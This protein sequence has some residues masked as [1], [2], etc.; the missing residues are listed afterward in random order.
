MKLVRLAVLGASLAVLVALVGV[1]LPEGASGSESD[2]QPA[3]SITV[4]GTGSVQTVP[5][6]AGLS[7][8]VT[9]QARSA[10]EALAAN[11]AAMQ[12]VIAAVRSAGVPA[13]DIQTSSVSLAPRTSDDGNTIVGYTATN[14]VSATIR[15]I[16]RAGAVI[17]LAVKAGANEVSGPMLTRS[18][19]SSLYRQALEAAFEDAQ[20]KASALAGSSGAQLGR[21]LRIVEGA[22]STPAP[23]PL[24][25][26]APDSGTPIEPGM[27]TLE[28]SVT[29]EF[30]I[31]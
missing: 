19:Q 14:T 21:V 22:G 31:S 3:R 30:E 4:T 8:G 7:L 6:R 26:A 15:S 16:D 11:G 9:T 20:A 28:T 17:D 13:A 10:A 18:D 29:V 24:A 27:Q 25:K 1:G 12:K 23:M 5:N 2:P